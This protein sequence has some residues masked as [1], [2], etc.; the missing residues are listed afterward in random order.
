MY[1]VVKTGGR[2]Y[3]VAVGDVLD[4]GRLPGE[5]GDSVTLPVVLVV[6]GADVTTD[7]E[8]L[9]ALPVLGEVVSQGRGPKIRIL[10]YKNKT[11]YRKRQGHRQDLT[12]LKVTGIGSV[13]AKPAATEKSATEKPAT[14]K[15][16]TEKT[17][18]PTV[19][20]KKD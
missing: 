8:A 3:R 17:T 16:A 20:V 9:A 15:S 14:E 7:A 18:A 2:Q 5:R 4:I 11:G 19:D 1:A 6:D 10:K 12:R 13:A